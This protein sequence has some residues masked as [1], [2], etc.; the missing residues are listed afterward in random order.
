MCLITNPLLPFFHLVHRTVQCCED[1]R[2]L[3]EQKKAEE[4][5]KWPECSSDKFQ[6]QGRFLDCRDYT[7]EPDP[8]E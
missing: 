8:C 2:K 1:M 7:P 4:Q 3:C 5:S 6:G